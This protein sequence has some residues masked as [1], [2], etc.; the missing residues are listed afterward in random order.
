M[1]L[2]IIIVSHEFDVK[3]NNNINIL[4]NYMKILNNEVDYC[5]ISNQD[6]FHNYES[7]ISF[8][9]KIINTKRQFSKIC[10]FI[11]DYEMNLD[12]DWYMKIRPDIKLLEN[13]NFDIMSNNAVNA[14]ARVYNGPSKIKYGMS[15]NGEG[16]WKNVG[17][18]HYSEKE[19]NIILDDQLFIF[20]RN[21]VHLKGFNKIQEETPGY[22]EWKQAAIFN[23]RNISM[24]VVGIYLEITKYNAFSGNI[25]I[26]DDF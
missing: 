16:R 10:D 19:H 1:K 17:D 20:H 3:W 2:L 7:L 12:Y 26:K 6:D 4:N 13:I 23:S 21:V 8:K 24:N 25:N 22:E 9:Y 5:G 11:T 15:V 18:C 14:R